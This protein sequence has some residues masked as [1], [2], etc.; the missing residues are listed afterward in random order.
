AGT[1]DNSSLEAPVL[2]PSGGFAFQLSTA[3]LDGDGRPDLTGSTGNPPTVLPLRNTTPAPGSVDFLPPA[4]LSLPTATVLSRIA[5]GDLDGDG[6]PDVV[7]VHSSDN[8][9]TLM[10]NVLPPSSAPIIIQP[11]TD[12]TAVAG[13]AVRLEVLAGGSEPL[14]FQWQREGADVPGATN[15]TLPFAAVT[16]ADAGRYRVL[17][18]NAFGTTNSPEASL[19]VISALTDVVDNFDTGVVDP[20]QWSDV[21]SGAVVN[22]IGGFVSAPFS[23]WFGTATNRHLIS[24][25]LDTRTSGLIRF[26]LRLSDGGDSSWERVDLPFEGVVLEYQLA[27]MTNWTEVA[28]LDTPDYYTWSQVQLLIPAAAASPATRFRWRQLRFTGE[29]FD[30]WAI[31]DVEIRLGPVAPIITRQPRSLAAAT[32]TPGTLAGEVLGTAPLQVQWFRDGA[33][34]PDQTNAVLELPPLQPADT[35]DYHFIAINDH[36]AVTSLV[37]RLTVYTPPDERFR[38]LS[39]TTNEAVTV[40]HSNFTGFNQG[41]LA[42]S[43]ARVFV[44]GSTAAARFEAAD[45]SGGRALNR[46]YWGLVTDLKSEVSYALGDGTNALAFSASQINSLVEID[47]VSGLPTARRVTLSPPIESR[48]QSLPV[49]LY[50]GYGRVVIVADETVYSVELPSGLVVEFGRLNGV[51]ATL[52]GGFHGLAEFFDGRLHLVAGVGRR[53]V[54]RLRVSDGA[55]EDVATF[56]DLGFPR[57]FSAS[58]LSGRWY[59]NLEGPSQFGEEDGVLGLATAQFEFPDVPRPPVIVGQPQGANVPIGSEAVLTVAATGSRPLA[60]Q[61]RQGNRV[62]TNATNASLR[63]A[64]MSTALAGNYSVIVSNTYGAVTSAIA[65]LRAQ[66]LGTQTFRIL[67]LTTRGVYSVPHAPLTGDDRGGI[68]ASSSQLFITG[69]SST[70][71][72]PLVTLAGGSSLSTRYDALTSDLET[73]TVYSLGNGSTPLTQEGGTVNALIELHPETGVPTGRRINVTPAF[74]VPGGGFS[75][76]VGIF[77]GYGRVVVHN[78][79][80]VY[81]IVL[82]SGIATD[83]GPVPV[84]A[85]NFSESWAYWGVAEFFDGAIHLVY[86]SSYFTISRMRVPEGTVTPL[87]EHFSG[88]ALGDIASLTVS[89]LNDRWYFHYEGGGF[90]GSGDEIAGYAEAQFE[91]NAPPTPPVIIAQPE[92]AT[93]FEGSGASF[94][95]GARGSKPLGY[96]WRHEGTDIPGATNATLVFATTTPSNA[97][98]YSVVV[99]NVYGAVTSSVAALTLRPPLPASKNFRIISLLSD[100][101]RVVDH[102]ALTGDDRGGIAVSATH[103]FYTGDNQTARFS[104]ADLSGGAAI[105]DQLDA[106]TGNLRS[107]T[108]Y[109]L[110]NGNNP[111]GF[112][113]GTVNGL[114][115]LDGATG[116][117]TTRRIALSQSIAMPEGSGI[118]AG[119]DRIV[120]H[121]GSRAYAVELPEGEVIDLGAMTTPEHW[122]CE[123]WAYWGV[124]EQFNGAIYLVMNRPDFRTIAR[125][126]VPDGAVEPIA[127]FDNLSD[128]C[129][130]SLSVA[131][132]RWYFHHEGGSQF[133]GNVETIGYA[134]ARFDRTAPTLSQFD[135]LLTAEDTPLDLDFRV[136]DP[137]T[138]ATNIV[139]TAR[140]SDVAVVAPEGL[141]I[142]GTGTNRTLRVIPV[143]DASGE[144][145]ITLTAED[146]A[147]FRTTSFF[148]LLVTPVNDSPS[149]A[150]AG[151]QVSAEDAG[152][153]RIPGWASAIRPGPADEAAQRLT[154]LVTPDTSVLFTAPPA[155]EPDGTLTYTSAPN[156]HGVATVTVHLRDDGGNDGGGRDTSDPVTFT[157]TIT[158]VCDPMV[159]VPDATN[160]PVA[161]PVIVAVLDNDA[162]LEGHLA[163]A[164]ATP[165]GHGSVSIA[166]T[167]VIYTPEAGFRG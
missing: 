59:F 78:G 130:F 135:D 5:I 29:T 95:V 37:A 22:Q 123:S 10:R 131:R 112:G 98:N 113:G 85:R 110:A 50:A 111:I 120:L 52:Y 60:Y 39:L 8:T 44:N 154:F 101:S 163:V 128:M 160:T 164:S 56:E 20:L 136:S 73:E 25:P 116:T 97:G 23:L 13:L 161:V 71:R 57:G 32:G 126:R 45:L 27:G 17:V 133:G 16:E 122:S 83:L 137:E 156:A 41:S 115:E 51:E 33:A 167:A 159:A 151:N 75:S 15:R 84:P 162:S 89:P 108:I 9:M 46:R 3:D 150:A 68:A 114:I 106:L 134:D 149:F 142:T 72:L 62:V 67:N 100:N 21:G 145:T 65:P 63:I 165:G 141:V 77:A 82:P 6:K 74:Q 147:G 58:V 40:V 7:G 49:G 70:A 125:V 146:A 96:Q 124:A 143:A 127:T 129:S 14:H 138:P 12:Q 119:Y 117:L 99:T 105:G 81:V 80:R 55:R 61:W 92:P 24:R 66:F 4:V 38:V 76:Q 31:D 79:T 36:G 54:Q 87:L 88:A 107:G 64:A 47:P 155:V 157:I 90:A 118:F 152:P 109:T 103:V 86:G 11:P 69:D 18:S 28:R 139:V 132:G 121:N 144:T 153:Q 26:Q 35:G 42:V 148:Y 19:T 1:F 93:V 94:R 102:D 48:N 166:A 158:P 53:N 91:F 104:A 30:H 34:L 43:P 140:S 2:F